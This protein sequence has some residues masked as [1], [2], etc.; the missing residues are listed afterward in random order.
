MPLLNPGSPRAPASHQVVRGRQFVPTIPQSTN[1]QF[2]GPPKS[3]G[4]MCEN[5]FRKPYFLAN[6]KMLEANFQLEPG[7]VLSDAVIQV[8]KHFATYPKEQLPSNPRGLF[9]DLQRKAAINLYRKKLCRPALK[10]AQTTSD[11]DFGVDDMSLEQVDAR[12]LL[13]FIRSQLIERL[14]PNAGIVWDGVVQGRSIAE[15]AGQLNRST[16][17]VSRLRSSAT[18]CARDIVVALGIEA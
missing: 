3:A 15:M 4:E 10:Q 6:A 9:C 17:T 14:G 2:P 18:R 13:Q 11:A 5:E 12:D 16:Q 1:E 8:L 7:S